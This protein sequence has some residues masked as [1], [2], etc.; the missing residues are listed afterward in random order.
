VFR[1]VL[2]L[3]PVFVL[4]DD[5]ALADAMD[6]TIVNPRSGSTVGKLI[7]AALKTSWLERR[8]PAGTGVARRT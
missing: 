1:L 7:R 3:P 5:T 6:Q 4:G 2:Q 8:R